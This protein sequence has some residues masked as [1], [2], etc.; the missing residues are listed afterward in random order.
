MLKEAIQSGNISSKGWDGSIIHAGRDDVIKID[1]LGDLSGVVFSCAIR[2]T[3]RSSVGLVE[4]SVSVIDESQGSI[5]IEL[6]KNQT[7]LLGK[8]RDKVWLTLDALY[9]GKFRNFYEGMIAIGPQGSDIEIPPANTPIETLADQVLT[10][11]A[12]FNA[13]GGAE[14]PEQNTNLALLGSIENGIFSLASARPNDWLTRLWSADTQT[15]YQVRGQGEY[16]TIYAPDRPFC[17]LPAGTKLNRLDFT[18]SSVTLDVSVIEVA[19]MVVSQGSGTPRQFTSNSVST[20]GLGGGCLFKNKLIIDDITTR[21][22][23]SDSLDLGGFEVPEDANAYA[24]IR[25]TGSA[26]SGT[27]PAPFTL[28]LR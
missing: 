25:Y 21:L 27:V 26:V 16:P 3:K 9:D 11:I 1:D 2:E 18:M 20:D 10:A 5:L 17:I 19:L 24:S 6:T 14:Q 7:A 28:N 4:P 22:K 12:D 8:G 23:F 13:S 15:H